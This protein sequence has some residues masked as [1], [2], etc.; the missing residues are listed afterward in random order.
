MRIRL[1]I[2]LPGPFAI[3]SG[4]S[5]RKQARLD[6][7]T[8]LFVPKQKVD[9]S[10]EVHEFAKRQAALAAQELKQKREARRGH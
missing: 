2:P 3:T 8:P 5:A 7:R 9:V 1:W 6:R 4:H 10:P